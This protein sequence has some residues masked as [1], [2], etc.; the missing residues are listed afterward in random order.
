MR[1]RNQASLALVGILAYCGFSCSSEYRSTASS[2]ADRAATQAPVMFTDVTAAAGL[3]SFRNVNGAF[4][5]KWYPEQMG[6]GGG[7][8]D[9]D[10]DGWEDLILL[11]GGNWN[12]DP[13]EKPRAV[14][15]FRNDHDGTF[16]DVTAEAGLSGIVTYSI[17]VSAADYDNDGDQDFYLTTLTRNMLFRNDGGV[18]TEVGEKTGVTDGSIWSSSAMFFDADRDGHLDLYVANY[19]DWTPQTDI[20]CPTGGT[21]KVYCAPNAYTGVQSR[22]F[23]NDGDGTFT[24][25][26][27]QAGFSPAIGKSLGVT[28]MDFNHDGWPDLAVS[29]DGEGDLL[30]QNRGNGTFEEIGVPV[31]FAFSEHGEAR[32]GMGIDSGI[33]DSTGQVTVV[34]GN[35]SEEM[36]GAY[37]HMKEG[38]FIDRASVKGLAYPTL[39]SLTFGLFLFDADLD[40]DLDLL[41]ANGH[42]HP[43]RA[44]ENDRITY[45]QKAQFFLNR[46]NGIFDEVKQERGPLSLPMVARGAAYADYDRDG[47]LDVLVTENDGPAHLWR[48]DLQGGHFLRVRL[49]GT[50]SN[51]DGIDARVLAR[52]GALQMERRVRT[53]SSYLSQSEKVVTFGLGEHEEVDTLVVEWPSGLVER[54]EGVQGNEEV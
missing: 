35:F 44:S 10:G 54:F 19:V 37:R 48:N 18:F 40:T 1:I 9:Y 21:V 22:F 12:E 45:R 4:G 14:W 30:Y 11:G 33:I 24:E 38:M 15:L 13:A 34:I 31:G 43:D 50:K 46:G 7:F 25:R 20:F 16:T 8:I 52:V 3:A 26:T 29:N 27:E 23:R 39:L 32:A 47:D 36:L 51:R 6:S 28:E 49:R 5:K 42:V 53:G 2:D 41:I 17:G